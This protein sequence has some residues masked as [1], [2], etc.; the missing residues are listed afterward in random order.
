MKSKGRAK[1]HY[2]RLVTNTQLALRH[3]RLDESVSRAMTPL[4]GGVEGVWSF[5]SSESS[6]GGQTPMKTL[7][8]KL[9]DEATRTTE[10]LRN[11]L[12]S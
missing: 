11:R 2:R 12:A 8:D 5:G 9:S 3:M 10:R 6:D 4:G 1:V 7:S